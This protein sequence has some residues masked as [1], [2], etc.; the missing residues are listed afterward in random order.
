MPISRQHRQ[1]VFDLL[2]GDFLRRHHGVELFI[3]DVAALLGGLDH[4]LDAGIGEIEQR[5]RRVGRAFG[6][7]LGR[8]FLGPSAF[9]FVAICFS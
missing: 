2:G 4:L 3:G 9:A 6:F 7:L 8:F 1:R 5:Q